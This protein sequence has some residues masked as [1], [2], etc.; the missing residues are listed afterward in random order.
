MK[1]K[2]ELFVYG[3]IW[4]HAAKIRLILKTKKPSYKTK[5]TKTIVQTLCKHDSEKR[6]SKF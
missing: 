5:P 2:T 1:Q 4:M 3:N 6:C